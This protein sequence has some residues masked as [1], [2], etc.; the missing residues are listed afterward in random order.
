MLDVKRLRDSAQ[1]LGVAHK[2]KSVGREHACE[3]RDYSRHDARGK[4]HD[5]IATKDD[6]ET[7][8]LPE[9]MV[10]ERDA[11]FVESHHRPHALIQHELR[12]F[13]A[14]VF[15]DAVRR[16]RA[17]RPRRIT[18]APRF[19]QRFGVDV[20]GENRDFGRRRR[21]QPQQRHRQRVGLLTSGTSGGQYPELARGIVASQ[22]RD[23]DFRKYAE[24]LGT[25]KEVGLADGKPGGEL[26]QFVAHR[27][28]RLEAL[29][30]G[31]GAA[32]LQRAHPRRQR[33]L[34]LAE[35]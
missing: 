24:L 28:F 32:A 16:R 3:P 26:A 1:R 4:V 18:A 11:A 17:H 5:Y 8:R 6:V 15:L 14:E 10:F 12:P 19:G 29:Q 31:V 2:E 22:P 27:Q 23:R 21:A 33:N 20:D 34:Q 25:A 7:M 30:V 35:R 9:L 13:A